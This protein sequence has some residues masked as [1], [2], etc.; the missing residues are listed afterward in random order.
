MYIY[1]IIYSILLII[2]FCSFAL[3]YYCPYYENG[4]IK[5]SRLS[6][7]VIWLVRGQCM[8]NGTIFSMSLADCRNSSYILKISGHISSQ[9]AMEQFCFP[10]LTMCVCYVSVSNRCLSGKLIVSDN[11]NN[12][13]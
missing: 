10:S 6:S 9:H 2:F 5:Y 8:I 7:G 12:N 13:W 11:N 4:L 3:Y 1:I